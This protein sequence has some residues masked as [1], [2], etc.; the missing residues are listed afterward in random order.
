[1]TGI[2]TNSLLYIV[3]GLIGAGY[4][5]FLKAIYGIFERLDRI[6]KTRLEC[7]REF[8]MKDDVEQ[9]KVHIWDKLGEH[10]RRLKDLEVTV[11]ADVR[12]R[13]A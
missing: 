13:G 9:G 1:M 12:R 4:G 8:A 3:M 7:L 11:A 5:V 2:D 6:E 10:D